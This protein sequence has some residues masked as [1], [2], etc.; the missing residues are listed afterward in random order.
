M[1]INENSLK[2]LKPF[3]KGHKMATGRPKG[4]LNLKTIL[5]N[6]LQEDIE[7]INVRGQK[8]EGIVADSI[9]VSLISK[10]MEG[11]INALKLI[12]ER[13][14]GKVTQDINVSNHSNI[15]RIKEQI[16]QRMRKEECDGEEK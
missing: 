2:N 5:K 4:S 9:N 8:Q 16:K 3:K 14:D 1:A 7:F 6:L 11:D 12:Y 15:D 13:I 10:A